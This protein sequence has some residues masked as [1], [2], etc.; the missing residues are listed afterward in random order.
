MGQTETDFWDALLQLAPARLPNPPATLYDVIVDG[1][2]LEQVQAFIDGGHD[3]G[4]AMA[5]GSPLSLAVRGGNVALFRLLVDAGAQVSQPLQS[6]LAEAVEGLAEAD[7]ESLPARFE[8]LDALI[9]RRASDAELVAGFLACTSR[10][11][12]TAAVRIARAGLTA[13]TPVRTGPR[14]SQPLDAWLA[15]RGA[16][17]FVPLLGGAEPTAAM[18]RE[19]AQERASGAE[20]RAL[21]ASLVPDFGRL[22]LAEPARGEKHRALAEQIRS[23]RW[24]AHLGAFDRRAGC[25]PLEFAA[26]N[27]LVD[28]VELVLP[29]TAD[30]ET[31][32]AA[33]AAAATHGRLECLERI[34][35]AAAPAARSA[36]AD[37]ALLAASRRGQ[38]ACVEYL[39][40]HGGNPRATDSNGDNAVMVAGGAERNLVVQALRERG[41]SMPATLRGGYAV[42]GKALDWASRRKEAVATALESS[43]YLAAWLRVD[44][45]ALTA[46]LVGD[47]VV[48]DLRKLPVPRTDGFVCY[49]LQGSPWTCVVPVVGT[50]QA[51]VE[52]SGTFGAIV[53]AL[54]AHFEAD[55]C[56]L[57]L[58]DTSGTRTLSA[59]TAGVEGEPV[60]DAPK[61]LAEHDLVLVP[62]DVLDN[63]FERQLVLTN[64]K[65]SEV[66]RAAF[67]PRQALGPPLRLAGAP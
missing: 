9:A 42:R 23:G 7:E 39:L 46:A 47:G 13:S 25:M 12:F 15:S 38:R 11:Q 20:A 35:E 18:Q 58:E 54:S 28:L 27:G 2:D 64:V 52:L 29:A 3:P 53:R 41:A 31:R 10:K 66:Q 37:A 57:V 49:R 30:I 36:V 26:R 1:G 14:Q 33:A 55:A 8:L 50:R 65:K 40:A 34:V 24:S 67:L 45:Q 59:W 4:V 61:G 56:M 5:G 44:V 6:L 16:S 48:A 21:R 60:A 19:E 32:R 17:V 62:H 22:V 43:P 51:M 63:G